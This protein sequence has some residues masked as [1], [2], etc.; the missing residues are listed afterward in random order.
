MRS[1]TS[2]G[3]SAR[4]SEPV[5]RDDLR[6]ALAV[7]ALTKPIN[8]LVPAGV[9][10]AGLLV[11]ATWLLVV[12][13]VVWLAMTGAT[14][15]DER[16]AKRVGERARAAVRPAPVSVGAPPG[17][18]APP[19][20]TRLRAARAARAS[21]RAAIADTPSALEDV[22]AEV[23]ALVVAMQADAVRAQRIHEFLAQESPA[24]LDQR[25][26]GERSDAV[27]VALES[28]REAVARVQQ[29][30]DRLLAELDHVVVTLQTVEAEILATGGLDDRALA[31]QVSELRVNVQLMAEGLEEAFAETRAHRV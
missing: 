5:S 31:G 8:V 26:A 30:L 2:T 11:G 22:S 6:R 20:A 15:F 18:F 21:I 1:R 13:I 27:R 12:A 23:D 10:V 28:K 24:E 9:V 25:I 3:K 17:P 7:N 16:E 14:F 29:R 4:S 19:I